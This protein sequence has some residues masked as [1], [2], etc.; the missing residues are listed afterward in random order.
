MLQQLYKA[1]QREMENNDLE[2]RIDDTIFRVVHSVGM[3]SGC[4]GFLFCC[5]QAFLPISVQIRPFLVGFY[6]CAF[7]I[8]YGIVLFIWKKS[9]RK[10]KKQIDEKQR[11]DISIGSFN[12]LWSVL[13]IG[14]SIYIT[15]LFVPGFS[16]RIQWYPF[17]FFSG[18]FSFSL[19]VFQRS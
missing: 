3:I 17:V 16:E 2:R 4:F 12:A 11:T 15:G 5:L 1:G 7:F 8:P 6:S 18:L 10:A 14:L 19:S 9:L 13:G